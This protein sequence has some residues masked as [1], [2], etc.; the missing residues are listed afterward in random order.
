MYVFAEPIS[1]QYF[2]LTNYKYDASLVHF[3]SHNLLY[4]IWSRHWYNLVS[5]KINF[6]KLIKQ[7]KYILEQ[8]RPHDEVTRKNY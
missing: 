1:K 2:D 5:I 7:R 4:W 6:R 3:L 8:S